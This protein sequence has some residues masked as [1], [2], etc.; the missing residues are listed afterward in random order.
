MAQLKQEP[1][2]KLGVQMSEKKVGSI[3]NSKRQKEVL[4]LLTAQ[5]YGVYKDS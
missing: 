3:L 5:I 4:D 1:G 2:S